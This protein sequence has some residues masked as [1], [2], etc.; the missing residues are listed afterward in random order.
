MLLTISLCT[1]F[2][3]LLKVSKP[4]QLFSLYQTFPWKV[5][6]LPSSSKVQSLFILNI[7]GGWYI[8]YDSEGEMDHTN[9]LLRNK[10]VACQVVSSTLCKL[11]LS[12]MNIWNK[13][14]R[15]VHRTCN[16]WM[17]LPFCS[18]YWNTCKAFFHTRENQQH[19]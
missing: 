1:R 10:A 11:P 15:C 16:F 17:K 6:W 12:L 14:N 19:I 8:C 5:P 18:I 3:G 2:C 9:S 13:E 4:H 7:L